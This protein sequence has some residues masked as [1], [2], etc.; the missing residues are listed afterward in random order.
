MAGGVCC[1]VTLLF[2]FSVGEGAFVIGLSKILIILMPE[3]DEDMQF[4]FNN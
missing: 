4:G 3:I 2:G 1:V